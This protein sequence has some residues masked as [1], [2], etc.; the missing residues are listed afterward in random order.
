MLSTKAGLYQ[1]PNFRTFTGAVSLKPIHARGRNQEPQHFRTFTGAV[2]LKLVDRRK[3]RP[4]APDFRTFTGAVSL[5]QTSRFLPAH[6]S[7]KLPHLHG[8]GLIEAA[9]FRLIPSDQVKLPH[10]HGC[11]LIEA[12]LLPPMA[13]TG[14]RTSAPSRVR[15]H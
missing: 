2:S 1:T 4:D 9:G 6:L 12:C 15:S 14:G 5:K 10:L 7:G 3:I 11:G 8:C 13:R